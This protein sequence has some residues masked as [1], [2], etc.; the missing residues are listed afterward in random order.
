MHR[1]ER[2]PVHPVAGQGLGGGRPDDVHRARA[3]GDEI[4][5][6][7]QPIA[8]DQQG[9]H[10]VAGRYRPPDHL[11]ALGDE[12]PVPGFQLPAQVDVGE[13]GVVRETRI[14]EV[15]DRDHGRRQ[16]VLSL[17]AAGR[18]LVLAPAGALNAPL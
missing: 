6:A 16:H 4:R 15:T 14:G 17:P 18:W 12:Q 3:A 7:G 1:G 11:L 8:G 13:P 10:R 2:A 5:Q 9:A